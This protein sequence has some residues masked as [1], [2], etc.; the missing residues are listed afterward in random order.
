VSYA[1]GGT[2]VNRLVESEV[3]T[4]ISVT[5][6]LRVILAACAGETTGGGT[7]S[8]TFKSPDGTKDRITATLT[9]IGNREVIVLDL[10]KT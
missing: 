1:G 6:A 9:T 4:G 3:E 2:I 5:Q 10:G 7:N 8:M